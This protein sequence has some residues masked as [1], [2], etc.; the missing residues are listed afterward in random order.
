[1]T[2]QTPTTAIDQKLL[3]LSIRL[4]QGCWGA[5]C[6]SKIGF[7]RIFILPNN[8]IRRRANELF[9]CGFSA[10][11]LFWPP[12][13]I[14]ELDAIN[15]TPMGKQ[16]WE[17]FLATH[18]GKTILD[19]PAY[20]DTPKVVLDYAREFFLEGFRAGTIVVQEILNM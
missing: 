6:C 10:R 7:T 15:E 8:K 11:M 17:N 20:P 4:G 13:G 19:G 5:Y 9:Q 12:T 18:E 14:I 1:M 2:N 16:A 3:D